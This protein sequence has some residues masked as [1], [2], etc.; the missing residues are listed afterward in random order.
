MQ[1]LTRC[2]AEGVPLLVQ[3]YATHGNTALRVRTC[4]GR[5]VTVYYS[6]IVNDV[7]MGK[8]HIWPCADLSETLFNLALEEYVGV[9]WQKFR[10][11]YPPSLKAASPLRARLCPDT[12]ITPQF[13]VGD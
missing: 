5:W 8:C 11:L 3:E 7:M 12:K 9:H 10:Q 1:R 2:D 13:C 4:E 6:D